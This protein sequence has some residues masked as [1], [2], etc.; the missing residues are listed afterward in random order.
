VSSLDFEYR[1]GKQVTDTVNLITLIMYWYPE[2]STVNFNPKLRTLKLG[3]LM[4]NNITNSEFCINQK[5]L[6]DSIEVFNH[7]E[8]RKPEVINI[9]YQYI[10]N[11]TMIEIERDIDTLVQGE[12]SLTILSLQQLAKNNII[13]EKNYSD[14]EDDLLEKDIIDSMLIKVKNAKGDPPMLAF[15]EE[16][17]VLVFNM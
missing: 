9:S 4:S 2:I 17:R 10:D 8:K 13:I 16:G 5:M 3:F 1:N 12:I 14:S 6:M 7:L 11:Y 15:R